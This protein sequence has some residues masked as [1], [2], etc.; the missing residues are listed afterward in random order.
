MLHRSGKSLA[1]QIAIIAFFVLNLIVTTFI[2]PIFISQLSFPHLVPPSLPSYSSHLS[3]LSH[4]PHPPRTSA[5]LIPTAQAKIGTHLGEGDINTQVSIMNMLAGKGAGNG[6]PVTIMVDSNVSRNDIDKLAQAVHQHNFFPIVRINKV[7]SINSNQAQRV[8]N[9]V[10]QAFGSQA[11]VA[12]GNEVNNKQVECSDYNRYQQNLR[13]LPEHKRLSPSA[14]DFYNADYPAK[15]FLQTTNL[16]N[17]YQTA[18]VR[19]ANAYGCTDVTNLQDCDPTQTNTQQIGTQVAGEGEQ[20]PNTK[21]YLT[22][23][24]LNPN[25]GKT[26]PDSDLDQVRTFIEQRGPETGAVHITPLVRN[27]CNKQSIKGQWLFY[28]HGDF[29]GFNARSQ[30][31]GL[32]KV[33]PNNCEAIDK[34]NPYARQKKDPDQYYLHS[35]KLDPDRVP[36][37]YENLPKNQY[38]WNLIYDQGYRVYKPSPKLSLTQFTTGSF[39]AFLDH[40][41]RNGIEYHIFGNS[42]GYGVDID[43][44]RIPLFRGSEAIATTEKISSY[45]GY[46][47]S[48][49]PENESVVDTGVAN[50]LLTTQQQCLIKIKNLRTVEQM[51]EQYHG[52]QMLV[53]PEACAFHQQIPDSDYYLYS[54]N[55]GE[56]A[57]RPSLLSAIEALEAQGVGCDQLT[58]GYHSEFADQFGVD[59]ETFTNVKQALDNMSLNLDQSYRWAFL[60]IAPLMDVDAG[61]APGSCGVGSGAKPNDR[62]CYLWRHKGNEGG[63]EGGPSFINRPNHAPIFAAL[64][65]PDFGTH[66]SLQYDYQD[67]AQ[68]TANSLLTP[69]Q[70]EILQEDL[71]NKGKQVLLDKIQLAQAMYGNA[72]ERVVLPIFCGGMPMCDCAHG[73]CPLRRALVDIINGSALAGQYGFDHEPDPHVIAEDAGEIHTTAQAEESPGRIFTDKYSSGDVFTLAG[74]SLSNES[75]EGNWKW[76]LKVRADDGKQQHNDDQ[77]TTIGVYMV[78]PIN[79]EYSTLAYLTEAMKVFFTQDQLA[80]MVE[81]NCIADGEGKCGELPLFYPIKDAEIGYKSSDSEEFYNPDKKC[82]MKPIKDPITGE[83]IGEYEDKP[84]D[85]DKAGIKVDDQSVGLFYPG[86][87]FGWF[88]RKIQQSLHSLGT[89]AHDY[90]TSCQRT[91]DMFLGQCRGDSQYYG[92]P[93]GLPYNGPVGSG[94]CEPVTAADNPCSIQNLKTHIAN[95]PGNKQQGLNKQ[96]IEKRAKK[97]SII[98][99][100]ESRGNPDAINT[101]CQDGTSVDYSVGLFQINLLAHECPQYFNYSW[102]PPWCEI[103][104][105]Q[106]K[107]DQCAHKV[108]QVEENIRYMLS[109]SDGGQDWSAWGAA[110]DDYC[111]PALDRVD[112]E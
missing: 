69:D 36:P 17:F 101:G 19:T 46:F 50:N 89:K 40:L 30:G 31:P 9:D 44:G 7:C 51:C 111:G 87:K 76:G 32:V 42:D 5:S 103:L 35:L 18:S 54:T 109:I 59:K 94:S 47:G 102:D 73:S 106:S 85:N 49:H 26:A 6:Y 66:H 81:T 33:T 4:T 68:L 82:P 27:V 77:K 91:E 67:S 84:C 61:T 53:Q 88:V 86:A 13:S 65:I 2:L 60:V 29:Y 38:I 45:E 14:L 62:F 75:G 110:G 78:A 105:N 23:F 70:Q 56:Q 21:L 72:E 104:V 28:L 97:A 8:A 1:A 100:W 63:P 34:E 12:F 20:I 10:R 39:G 92:P 98:C 24:S 52:D 108:G 15:E 43:Q 71:I 48:N 25:G 57:Q 3:H 95:W 58:Q 99:N 22:E 41:E 64:K 96:Q 11:V 16:K 83:K 93:D 37:G 90:I 55:Q 112:A 74:N 79:N 107:V 80:K